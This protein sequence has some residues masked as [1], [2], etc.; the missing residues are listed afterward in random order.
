MGIT[1]IDRRMIFRLQEFSEDPALALAMISMIS[2]TWALWMILSMEFEKRLWIAMCLYLRTQT[3]MSK[4]T[5]AR[6]VKPLLLRT[7]A[8][9]M[10]RS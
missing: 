2:K 3:S 1:M 5:M 10:L 7:T 9:E 4:N 6:K 8:C